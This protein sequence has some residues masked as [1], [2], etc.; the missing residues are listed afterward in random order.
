MPSYFSGDWEF[1]PEIGHAVCVKHGIPETPCPQCL[2]IADPSVEVILTAMDINALDWDHDLSVR[3]LFP[4][5]RAGDELC[6]RVVV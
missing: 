3:D 1:V 2:A 4:E 5:G 6:A